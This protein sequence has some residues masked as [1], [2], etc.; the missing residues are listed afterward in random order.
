MIRYG[1]VTSI[2][3]D[4]GTVKVTFE[5]LDIPSAEIPVLQGRTEKTKH[6]SMPKIGESGICIFPENSFSGFY[7]GSGYND[8]TPIPISAK[9]GVEITVFNDGTII[10]YDE[11]SSKLYINCNNKIEIVAQNIKITCPETE[12]IGDI[13]VTGTI[14]VKG[15]VNASKE[16]SAKGIELSEHT[17]SGIKAGGDTTGGPQ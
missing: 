4:K 3:S 5:D 6:Y 8:A 17:H 10:S 9:E 12:I 2:F 7:L 15:S 1:T 11:K 16:V 14:D 13:N